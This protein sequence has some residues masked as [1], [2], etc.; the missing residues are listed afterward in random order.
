MPSRAAT[1]TK[2]SRPVQAVTAAH[3]RLGFIPDPV[4][5]AWTH[6]PLMRTSERTTFARCPEQWYRSYVQRIARSRHSNPL[7]FGS[8]VHKA[9]E[10]YYIPG[11]RRGPHPVQ[12]FLDEYDAVAEESGFDFSFQDEDEDWVQARELGEEMLTNYVDHWKK[13]DKAWQVL[14][15]EMPA[16]VVLLSKKGEPLCRYLMQLDLVVYDS[17]LGRHL[18][19]DHKTAAALHDPEQKALD[20]Q[21]GT[22]W[23]FGPSYLAANGFL[24]KDDEIRGFWYNILRKAKKDERPTNE[25]GQALNKDG[26]VS[27]RQPT[28][29][30]QRFPVYADEA[31]RANV[32]DRIRKQFYSMEQTRKGKLGVYKV[33]MFSGM[34]SCPSCQFYAVCILHEDGADHESLLELDYEESDPY[35]Q[36]RDLLNIEED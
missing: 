29:L 18:F 17:E 4:P 32:L 25:A 19:V 33:P 8:M 23:L 14:A 24:P 1:A 2:R 21:C 10:V 34:G 16:M 9:L 26:S 27:K 7:L 6:L 22:Y 3:R 12:T 28:P 13:R 35:G 5:E 20:E 31:R 36:Y 15:P 11:K 30:F